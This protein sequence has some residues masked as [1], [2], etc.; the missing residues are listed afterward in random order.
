MSGLPQ[1]IL[2]EATVLFHDTRAGDID[3]VAHSAFV[4]A[5]VLDRGS[6]RSVAALR[7]LYGLEGIRSF[8]LDGGAFQVSRR[9]L[10]LW[11]AVLH[12]VRQGVLQNYRSSTLKSIIRRVGSLTLWLLLK[13]TT[14]AMLSASPRRNMMCSLITSTAQ[15]RSAARQWARARRPHR[16]RLC[17]KRG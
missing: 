17:R 10:A 3:P 6:L 7:R 15:P 13:P 11:T 9:T 4:I 1:A 2:D 12:S 5:R 8:L 14:N 16:K